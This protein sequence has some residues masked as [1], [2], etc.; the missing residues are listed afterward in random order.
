MGFSVVLLFVSSARL[1]LSRIIAGDDCKQSMVFDSTN[2][3]LA[4]DF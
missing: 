3:G 1:S 2:D 4:T